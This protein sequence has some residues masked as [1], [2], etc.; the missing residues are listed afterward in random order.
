MHLNWW[1]IKRIEENNNF[2]KTAEH[3]NQNFRCKNR[4]QGIYVFIFLMVESDA[5]I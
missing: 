5:V 4:L 3:H 1:S 2:H